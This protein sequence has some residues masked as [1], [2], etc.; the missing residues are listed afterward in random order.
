[1]GI[2]LVL[3]LWKTNLQ[4]FLK[5][6]AYEYCNIVLALPALCTIEIPAQGAKGMCTRMMVAAYS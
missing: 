1:M 3:F 2:Y 5:L 6:E 4:D